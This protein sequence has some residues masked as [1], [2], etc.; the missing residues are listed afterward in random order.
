VYPIFNPNTYKIWIKANYLNQF[1]NV[2]ISGNGYG[3]DTTRT[4]YLNNPGIKINL[5]DTGNGHQYN[6]YM[7][8]HYSVY[9]AG[10]WRNDLGGAGSA[11]DV[12]GSD[13]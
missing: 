10:E 8:N 9:G 5:D 4:Y 13:M 6:L 11:S 3:P 1:R 7:D 12:F 2:I